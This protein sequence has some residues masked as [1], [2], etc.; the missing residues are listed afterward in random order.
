MRD[1]AVRFRTG[2]PEATGDPRNLGTRLRLLPQPHPY[3][4]H[5][6]GAFSEAV[7]FISDPPGGHIKPRPLD[8]DGRPTDLTDEQKLPLSKANAERM[9]QLINDNGAN[10]IFVFTDGSRVEQQGSA[11]AEACA[12]AYI[13]TIGAN[14]AVDPIKQHVPVSPIA[15]V[16]SAELCSIGAAL[17]YLLHN[18]DSLVARGASRNIVIVTDSKSSLDAMKGTWLRRIGRSEQVALLAMKRLVERGLAQRIT[19]AFVFSHVSTP[20]FDGAPGNT[21]VDALAEEA[22]LAVGTTWMKDQWHVDTTRRLVQQQHDAA[23]RALAASNADV[24]RFQHAPVKPNPTGRSTDTRGR[25]SIPLPSSLSREDEMRLYRARVGVFSAAGGM[26]HNTLE[27]CPI[28]SAPD[29]LGRHGATMR[30]LLGCM[31]R[32]FPDLAIDAE[33]LWTAPL[34]AA[35]KLAEWDELVRAAK[36]QRAEC[37]E[38]THSQQ[39]QSTLEGGG[40]SDAVNTNAR[41]NHPRI[42]TDA[43]EVPPRLVFGR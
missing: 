31:P 41:E 5:E 39:T 9:Q 43:N 25:P 12:G 3:A 4:P 14:P 34:D 37:E 26:L 15:C 23:S 32:Y 7:R 1:L 2:D 17:Y 21:A 27:R 40:Q 13:I 28:C 30:H 10:A 19:L 38:E 33:A 6:L 20:S 22:R 24:F 36:K 16:Y 18:I 42:S 11:V 35:A 29:V 8:A